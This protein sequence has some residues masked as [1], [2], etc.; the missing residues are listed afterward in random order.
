MNFGSWQSGPLKQ[1]CSVDE[2]PGCSSEKDSALSA[3]L[4]RP[5]VPYWG[6]NGYQHRL[7]LR[8]HVRPHKV[9]SIEEREKVSD[10]HRLSDL[11]YMLQE[12]R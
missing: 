7:L 2:S 4:A 10:N 5:S 3:P 1:T 6:A 11:G 12:Q 9:R 8:P